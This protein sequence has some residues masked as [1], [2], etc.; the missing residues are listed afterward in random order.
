VR[1]QCR[2]NLLVFHF[3]LP[4]CRLSAEKAGDQ[5]PA[6]GAKTAPA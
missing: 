1:I 5:P 3:T 4:S 2:S 6:K